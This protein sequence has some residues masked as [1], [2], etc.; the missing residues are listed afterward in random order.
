MPIFYHG[1]SIANASHMAAIPGNIDVTLGGG[2]YG[3]GFYTQ[4]SI[5]NAFRRGRTQHGPNGAVLVVELDDAEY[6][7]LSIDYLTLN[8]A[9]ALNARLSGTARNTYVTA[10]DVI[11]GPLV[12]SPFIEQ[13]K[14][15]SISAQALLNGSATTR[16]VR[17]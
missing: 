7:A 10:D 9:Q 11:V 8:Q 13:Q 6:H 1:T 12:H 16:S 4:S 2:E 15:Q 14:C 5:T 17:T 3:R